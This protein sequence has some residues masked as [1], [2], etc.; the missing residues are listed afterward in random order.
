MNSGGRS[1]CYTPACSQLK[2]SV[3]DL[4]G[5]HSCS[6]DFW[7]CGRAH[8]SCYDTRKML[9]SLAEMEVVEVEVSFEK[10]CEARCVRD[11]VY[12]LSTLHKIL[13]MG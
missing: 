7:I 13:R 4:Q 9:S 5:F 10:S 12:P 11:L 8:A 2:L 6:A 1:G 3:S